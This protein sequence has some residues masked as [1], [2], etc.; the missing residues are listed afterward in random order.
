MGRTKVLICSTLSSP[1]NG[2]LPGKST[3]YPIGQLTTGLMPCFRVLE[4]SCE[5]RPHTRAQGSVQFGVTHKYL[6]GEYGVPRFPSYV[7]DCARPLRALGCILLLT[8]GAKQAGL[9]RGDLVKANIRRRVQFPSRYIQSLPSSAQQEA[10][11]TCLFRVGFS[12]RPVV[13]HVIRFT[14]HAVINSPRS[15]LRR[16]RDERVNEDDVFTGNRGIGREAR[17]HYTTGAWTAV[18]KRLDT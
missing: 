14:I 13:P 5:Q 10:L 8:V 3:A 7:Q 1:P 15:Y 11:T 12:K 18:V 16:V 2:N 4:I 6:V 9:Q 17:P